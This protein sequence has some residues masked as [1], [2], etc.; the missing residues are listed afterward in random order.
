MDAETIVER[1]KSRIPNKY[2]TAS[3]KCIAEGVL[4]TL[5]EKSAKVTS[6]ERIKF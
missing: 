1:M 5:D 6:V 4:F 2:K 3:G